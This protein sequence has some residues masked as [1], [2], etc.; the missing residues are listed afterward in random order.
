VDFEKILDAAGDVVHTLSPV[1]AAL[2]P[3][4][5]APLKVVELGL[6]DANKVRFAISAAAGGATGR[7]AGESADRSG[8]LT[9]IQEAVK[10]SAAS[11]GVTEA[12][13][14]AIVD[15]VMAIVRARI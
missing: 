15:D 12:I 10:R 14:L 4:A 1:I 8:K 11:Y 6:E 3:G 13:Q 5:A 9:S 7:A 2:I